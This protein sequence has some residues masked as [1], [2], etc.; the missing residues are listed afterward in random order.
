MTTALEVTGEWEGTGVVT[1]SSIGPE[2]ADAL[3]ESMTER[4]ISRNTLTIPYPYTTSDAETWIEARVNQRRSD[5]MET[6]LAIRH[7]GQF[8]GVVGARDRYDPPDHL[9]TLGYWLAKPYWGR[10]I[11]TAAVRRFVRYCFDDLQVKRLV[12]EVFLWN[13]ASARVLEKV[14]FEEEGY[15]RKHRKK[16]DRL[17]DVRYFGLLAED[18][19]TAP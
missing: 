10:G 9:A 15:L 14:G 17:V 19:K 7:D 5:P 11:T 12:A 18:V 2:D 4:A 8:I 1:L 16:E 13:D 6:V 3:V